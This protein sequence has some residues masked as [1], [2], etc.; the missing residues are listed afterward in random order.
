MKAN[1]RLLILAALL[2]LVFTAKV[3]AQLPN[4]WQID[5]HT[6]TAGFLELHQPSERRPA[7]CGHQ[8]RL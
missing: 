6:N 5:D 7:H 8:R 1:K 3:R 4:A 2:S